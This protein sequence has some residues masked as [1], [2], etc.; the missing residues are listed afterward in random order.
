VLA[1]LDRT[2][3]TFFRRVHRGEKAGFPRFKGRNRYHSFTFQGVRQRDATRQ[4]LSRSVQDRTHQHSLVPP[5][6]RY[7]QDRHHLQRGRRVVCRDF[8]RRRSNASPA[9]DGPRDR[10]RLGARVPRHA[11]GWRTD[12]HPHLQKRGDSSPG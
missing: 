10:H 5:N 11:G 2:Y 12:L 3:Q 6:R 9:D 1:R 8:L 4:W 7:A